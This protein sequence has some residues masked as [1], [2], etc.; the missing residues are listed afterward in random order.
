MSLP[1][2]TVTGLISGMDT[3]SII[4]QLMSIERRPLDLLQGQ[5]DKANAQKTAFTTI[6]TSLLALKTAADSLSRLDNWNARTATV[7]NASVLSATASSLT[8]VG[9]YVFKVTQLAAAGQIGSNGYA[10]SDT[11]PIGAGSFDLTVGSTTESFTVDAADTLKD[12][13]SAINDREMGV[14]AIVVNTGQGAEPYKLVL[15]SKETGEANAVSVS[16]NTVPGMTFSELTAAKDA[17]IEFGVDSPIEIHSATNTVTGL[18]PG[19]TLDLKDTSASAVTVTVAADT[20]GTLQQAK[21]FV[22]KY[23]AVMDNIAKYTKYDTEAEQAAALFGNSTLRFMQSDLGL[24]ISAVVEDQP[25]ETNSL[26]MVGFGLGRDGKLELDESTFASAL[27]AHADGVAGLFSAITDTALASNGGS[28]STGA[29]ADPGFDVNDLIN[30]LTDSSNFGSGNGFQTSTVPASFTIDFGKTR[31]IAQLA[32]YNLDSAAMPAETYGASDFSF[33]LQSPT[34][35]WTTVKTV[36]GFNGP[37]QFFNLDQPTLATAMRV[38]VTGTN[39]PDGAIRL[40]E[41]SANEETGIAHRVS[42]QLE[43][44]T[45]SVDGQIATEQ[46]SLD[47]KIET[48]QK[49]MDDMQLRLDAKEARLRAD[50]TAMETAMARMQAQSQQFSAQMSSLSSSS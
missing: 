15:T 23:N 17:V 36:A 8:P 28:I 32:L 6:N 7:S 39:A 47:T 4:E 41:L 21:D 50:F 14:S 11:T 10:D 26:T 16:N 45:R 48:L 33:E 31:S 40:L 35:A 18:A 19:L 27:A 12:V 29:A 38:N 37:I 46:S 1:T 3:A 9:A 42:N 30:G 44:L 13:A 5:I 43:F 25:S 2:T 20:S 22:T 49:Q 34:G 24:A